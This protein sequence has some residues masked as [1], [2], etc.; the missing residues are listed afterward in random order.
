MIASTLLA[1]SVFKIIIKRRYEN[2]DNEWLINYL[3]GYYIYP[4]IIIGVIVFIVVFNFLVKWILKNKM[5]VDMINER[6]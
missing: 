2:V 3:V 6:I 4:K 5:P 1:D